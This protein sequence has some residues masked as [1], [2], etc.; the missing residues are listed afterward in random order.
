MAFLL[1]LKNSFDECILVVFTLRVKVLYDCMV[2]LRKHFKNLYQ[3]VLWSQLLLV[4][5]AGWL[6]VEVLIVLHLL[7][8][9][10]L[11]VLGN[12]CNIRQQFVI[13]VGFIVTLFQLFLLLAKSLHFV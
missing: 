5:L 10:H 2:S 6:K 1:K 13:Y 9:I 11:Q 8:L 12:F 3:L 7:I 4:I